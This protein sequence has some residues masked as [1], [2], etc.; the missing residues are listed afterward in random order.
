MKTCTW[1]IVLAA[2][3]VASI[4]TP[5][6]TTGAYSV[7]THEELIDLTWRSAIRPLLLERYPGSTDAQL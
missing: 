3:T 6:A 1:R 2:V 4:L 5:Q 7:F